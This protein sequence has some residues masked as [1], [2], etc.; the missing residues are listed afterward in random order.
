MH[1]AGLNAG[2]VI[3][4]NFLYWALG[5]VMSKYRYLLKENGFGG[6]IYGKASV[7]NV[8]RRIPFLDLEGYAEFMAHHGVPVIQDVEAIAPPGTDP[9]TLVEIDWREFSDE[10]HGWPAVSAFKL[11]AP[12]LTALGL[13]TQPIFALHTDKFVERFDEVWELAERA[14]QAQGLRKPT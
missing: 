13:P 9:T 4:T 2:T 7:H 5:A 10:D 8:W 14:K 12:I 6:T 3:D 1:S 11:W